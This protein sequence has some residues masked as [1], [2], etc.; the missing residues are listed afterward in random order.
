MGNRTV[1][2]TDKSPRIYHFILIPFL[3]LG[4]IQ[5]ITK[6]G[7]VEYITETNETVKHNKAKNPSW[8][9]ANL[10]AINMRGRGYELETAVNKSSRRSGQ[11]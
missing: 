8:P 11:T 3:P 10:L 1:R 4:C 9:E 2:Y 7:G 6:P 5:C